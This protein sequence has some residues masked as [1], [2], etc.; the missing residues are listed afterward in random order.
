MGGGLADFTLNGADTVQFHFTQTSGSAI[1][2]ATHEYN[3][4]LASATVNPIINISTGGTPT[5]YTDTGGFVA[6]GNPTTAF[7]FTSGSGV[8]ATGH[9][10][11]IDITTTTNL[12]PAG[13]TVFQ[14]FGVAV[15]TGVGV[16]APPL[17]CPCRYYLLTSHAVIRR[18]GINNGY[19]HV[20]GFI[21]MMRPSTAP[22]RQHRIVA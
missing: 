2:D 20:V 6:A 8:V 13:D 11:L 21:K 12:V 15:G 18:L 10:N 4:V 14:A 7:N 16:R 19:H 1:N 3:D 17:E 9:N 22:T 5:T